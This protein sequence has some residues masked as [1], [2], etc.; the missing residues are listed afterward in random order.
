MGSH[1]STHSN[2]MDMGL[3]ANERARQ[4]VSSIR[5]LI[6]FKGFLGTLVQ[7]ERCS[8]T[9]ISRFLGFG[10]LCAPTM[11]ATDQIGTRGLVHIKEH[12]K[13]YILSG[14]QFFLRGSWL[15]RCRV[16]Y[17]PGISKFL[18]LGEPNVPTLQRTGQLWSCK[19]RQMKGHAKLHLL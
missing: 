15:L 3:A 12:V 9:G 17:P 4:T 1:R 5:R 11:P 19:W 14:G 16:K 10:E 2:A 18:V 13:L 7:G 6:F 8:H